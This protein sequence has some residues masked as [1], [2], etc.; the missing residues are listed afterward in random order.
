MIGSAGN[1]KEELQIEQVVLS[2]LP[3]GAN[4]RQMVAF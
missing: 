2:I 1:I 3:K 4:N